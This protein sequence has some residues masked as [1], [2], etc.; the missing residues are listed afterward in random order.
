MH[1]VTVLAAAL[2]MAPPSPKPTPSPQV[3]TVP[4]SF[5]FQWAAPRGWK[6]E[7]IPFPLEFAPTLDYVGLEELRFSP[8]FGKPKEPLYFTYAF[9]WVVEGDAP[10]APKRLGQD[11]KAYFDGLMTAVAKD[12]AR[13]AG[14]PAPR[15]VSSRATMVADAPGS[16]AGGPPPA[17]GLALVP[18]ARG[19]VNSTDSFYTQKH[20]QLMVRVYRI[21]PDLAYR[22]ALYFELSPAIEDEPVKKALA[23]VRAALKR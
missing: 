20:L 15:P 12:K 21:Q 10:P 17:G 1:L 7:T 3:K 2:L 5:P 4:V 19:T 6:T 18:Y 13:K 8:S 9:V 14:K 11:L 22:Q 16:G 23:E